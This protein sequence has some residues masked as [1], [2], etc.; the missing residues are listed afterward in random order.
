MTVNLTMNAYICGAIIIATSNLF[1]ITTQEIEEK[2][3]SQF[4]RYDLAKNHLI[5]TV[6]VEGKILHRDEWESMLKSD[7][8]LSATEIEQLRA[9][10]AR[11]C[12][13][14]AQT[15]KDASV[16][17]L[18]KLR[19]NKR[20]LQQFCAELPKGG[21]LH[22]HPSGTVNREVAH[23]MLQRSNPIISHTQVHNMLSPFIAEHEYD[24]LKHIQEPTEYL[25]LEK[26]V[27]SKLLDL[28]ILPAGNSHEFTRFIG[29]FVLQS[30]YRNEKNNLF[31]AEALI[32]NFLSQAKEHGVI[33]VEFNNHAIYDYPLNKDNL[34]QLATHVQQ[35]ESE[36]G[37]TV[38]FNYGFA[39]GD[40]GDITQL[41][42]N[43]FLELDSPYI[44]GIDLLG[45]EIE[46]PAFEKGQAVYATVNAAIKHQKRN[47]NCT[48]H[49]GELGDKRNPRDAIILGAKRIGHGVS[50]IDDVVV[51]EYA[52][53]QEQAIETNLI[54]N[55]RLGVHLT[56]CDHP[57]L[58][59]LRLG[60]K[61]SLSTDDEGM[62]ETNISH[63]FFVAIMETDIHYTEVK[64][65]V[66]NSIETA[67]ADPH[68]KER[69]Q[70]RLMLQ[71]DDFEKRWSYIS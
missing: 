56:A 68:T 23:I 52:R 5:Q 13:L 63:E 65:L 18:D 40:E 2:L 1:A 33:Y 16:I 54:S 38:R 14:N 11:H 31:M 69:L 62:F 7:E 4:K 24:F 15:A 3:Q 39:R 22:V 19:A 48:M 17:Y 25:S 51:L 45:S 71:F 43:K 44:T 70:A 64:Q 27:Q 35:W 67:F 8:I 32:R 29:L 42:A 41:Q 6:G 53:R 61:P 9:D 12:A 10:H 30:I 21:M 50:L 58:T 36:F 55:Q 47:L 66:L 34:G 46:T 59:Y 26:D 37:I 57:F 60:L 20:M 49:A 28:H